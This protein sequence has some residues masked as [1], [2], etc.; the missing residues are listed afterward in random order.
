MH[1]F[2]RTLLVSATILS[3]FVFAALY[4]YG[5]AVLRIEEKYLEGGVEL[6]AKDDNIFNVFGINNSKR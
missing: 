4:Q 2:T 5:F 1:M 6:L 3:N